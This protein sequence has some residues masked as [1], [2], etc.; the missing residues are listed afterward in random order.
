MTTYSR[1][2]RKPRKRFPFV[3]AGIVGVLSILIL[4]G[5]LWFFLL[6]PQPEPKAT[7]QAQTSEPQA[8]SE[9]QAPAQQKPKIIDLQPV[10]DAW[11]A[12]QKGDYGIVVYDPA[13]EQAIASHDA[14]LQFFT[15]S[16]Y[17]IF[18]VYLALQDVDAGKHTL[19]EQFRFGKTRQT[20]IYDAIHSSDSPCAEALM[21]EIGN[22]EVNTRLKAFGFTNTAFPGFVTTAADTIKILQRIQAKK[23]LSETSTN[24]LLD[25]MKTQIYRKGLPSGFP[26]GT[27]ADKVGFSETPHYHDVGILTLPSGR[28]YLVAYFS[29]SA[30]SRQAADF[31]STIYAKLLE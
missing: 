30:G 24:L 1:T 8:S 18:V 12:K 28:Q 11:I 25:A 22:E 13:N 16:I 9:V 3:L 2:Y 15:A 31:A 29:K 23:E 27:I 4:G 20:C 14:D 10:V 21:A 26:E 5:G 17:K 19:T 7:N 6:R